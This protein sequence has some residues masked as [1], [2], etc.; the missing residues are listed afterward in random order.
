MR[1]SCA[2]IAVVREMIS[3]LTRL[4]KLV[5]IKG[6]TGELIAEPVFKSGAESR[7]T[8][9]EQPGIYHMSRQPWRVLSSVQRH[10]MAYRE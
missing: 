6:R 5:L 2:N 4:P 1:I 3:L 10:T 8:N 7:E 9:E